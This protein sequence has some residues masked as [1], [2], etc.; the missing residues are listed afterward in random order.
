MREQLIWLLAILAA[1]GGGDATIDS[2]LP[3]DG[4]VLDAPEQG[5][6]IT[7][8]VPSPAQIPANV[9]TAVT[10]NWSYLIEPTLPDPTCS[11]DKGVGPVTRGQVT[12]VTIASVTTFTI[13]CTNT[14]GMASRQVVIGVP[15]VAPQIATF[16]ATPAQVP[17]GASTNVTFNWTYT[18]PPSPA[19]TCTIEHGVG[20]VTP[21][22]ISALNLTQART[23]RLRCTNGQGTGTGD[24]TVTVNECIANTDDCGPNATCVDTSDGFSCM[25][26]NGFTG[27]GDVCSAQVSCGVTPSLCD[28]NA[29]CVGGAAC[30]CN[31]GY[32][33]SGT[34]CERLRY[35]FVTSSTGNGNLSSWAGA[36]GMTGLAAADAV[37]STR[38]AT[39]GLAGTYVAWLSDSTNDAYCRANG[40]AGKRSNNCGLA[41][42]PAAAG[43]WARPNGTPVAPTIDRMVAP[44]YQQFFPA[45]SETSAD[46]TSSPLVVYTGTDEAGAASAATC[47]D[48]TV[49]VSSIRGNAGDVF[50]GGTSWT[51]AGSIDPTCD[52]IGRLRCVETTPGPA[53]PSRH[54]NAK[55]AFL[56]SVTGSGNLSTWADAGGTSGITAADAICQAR[57]RYA[58][59][60]NAASFKAWMSS[61]TSATSR[62]LTNGPWARPDGVVIG[63]SEFDLTDGRLAAPLFL[64]EANAYVAGN[65]DAGTV[66]T[67]TNSSGSAS[68]N[69]CS[70]WTS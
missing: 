14:G 39:A 17:S 22:T 3:R 25:C 61:G 69:Y 20:T 28:A 33:G 19:P 64:T 18:T 40:L 56:T 34:T 55:K 8:F 12:S 38:A 54:P 29:S 41:T 31:A 37:C 53:L 10:W 60:L 52:A 24:A 11:I 35:T 68:F 43:P 2:G 57:A 16:T 50:G 36:N 5:P 7:A 51:D 46:V 21:G 6:T 1:C 67:G 70:V 58:G 26:N 27:N 65:N 4:I 30:V 15:P 62:I 49:S 44:T 23:Y 32:V 42:L 45:G 59:Y 13:T 48:W 63:T 47:N 66:W 9:P